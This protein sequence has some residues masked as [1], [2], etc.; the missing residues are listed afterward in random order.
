[1]NQKNNLPLWNGHSAPKTACARK[2]VITDN[3]NFY[4]YFFP[5]ISHNLCKYVRVHDGLC[6][7]VYKP[8]VNKRNLKKIYYIDILFMLKPPVYSIRN[9][10]LTFYCTGNPPLKIEGQKLIVLR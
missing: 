7:L 8:M 9:I 4:A 6:Q 5:Q 10:L 1:M 3:R 2:H